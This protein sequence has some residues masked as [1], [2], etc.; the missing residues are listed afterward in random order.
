MGAFTFQRMPLSIAT[1]LL[2]ATLWNLLVFE[3]FSF[4][5]QPKLLQDS[6]RCRR[7]YETALQIVVGPD[8]ETKPD[9]ENIH[10]PLGK[11]VDRVFLKMFRSS[12]AKNTGLDSS[13]PKVGALTRNYVVID[14][15][16]W[17]E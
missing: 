10:G 11:E 1:S 3:T 2:F 5:T 8:P 6:F 9:Y 15:I 17:P 12:L 13:L 14:G 7:S 4:I 16:D